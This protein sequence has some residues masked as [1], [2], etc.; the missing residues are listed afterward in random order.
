MMLRFKFSA[1]GAILTLAVGLFSSP[2]WAQ[3]DLTSGT[4]FSNGNKFEEKTGKALYESICQGCHMPDA[5]GATGAGTYPALANNPRLASPLYP[6]LKVVQGSR[7]MPSFGGQLD[8][9]QVV[10]VVNYVRSHFGNAYVDTL[11]AAEV[12]ALRP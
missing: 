6:A 12:K 1:A 7:A 3:A 5:K 8:D 11:T 10:E 9:A 4:L 2:T